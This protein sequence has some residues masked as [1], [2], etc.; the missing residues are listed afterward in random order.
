MFEIQGLENITI[1]SIVF[2]DKNIL[3]VAKLFKGQA[4]TA[5]TT[6]AEI[7]ICVSAFY[8]LL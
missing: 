7:Y 5:D 6:F 2:N 1:E 8:C 4:S 3:R